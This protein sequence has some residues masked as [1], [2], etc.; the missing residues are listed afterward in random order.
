MTDNHFHIVSLTSENVKRIKAVRI[1]ANGESVVI[2]GR[3][4][5]G[6]SS[7]LDSILYALGGTKNIPDRPVR[8]GEDKAVIEVEVGDPA[9][10]YTI[11]R[12]I[13]AKGGG[14]LTISTPDGMQAKSPQALLDSLLGPMSFDPLSF[15]RLSPKQQREQLIALTGLDTSAFDSES[16]NIYSKRTETGRDRDRAKG[17]AESLPTYPNAPADPISAAELL[18]QINEARARN[19]KRAE[20]IRQGRDA[21]QAADTLRERAAQL[22][23]EADELDK[24]AGESHA[25]AARL[26]GELIATMDTS[27]L[28]RQL[29]D[30]EAVNAQVRANS[31]AAAASADADGLSIKYKEL[32]ARI[33][34][35]AAAKASALAAVKMPIDGLAFNDSGVTLNGVPLN[36]GSQ[37]EQLR[38]AVSIATAMNPKLR[39]ALIREAAVLDS[40]SMAAL[41]T[42]AKAADVQLF[43]ERVGAEAGSIV[44]EDG[45]VQS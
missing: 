42:A 19:D 14:T 13:T 10:K 40:D 30:A 45:E 17:Y 27:D 15:T 2:S 22:R 36:Q 37:A 38:V 12:T 29:S 41:M 44:I 25:V 26:R 32:T 39:I 1:E 24:R 33:D 43:V 28:E 21:A 18:R 34:E 23:A 20:Q 31:T 16:A 9:V 6:K 8:D 4:A 3:N 35:I 7:I 11:K 5:Q